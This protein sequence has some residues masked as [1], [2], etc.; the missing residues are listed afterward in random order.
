MHLVSF[1]D[2]GCCGAAARTSQLN[3]LTE[4]HDP[5]LV[6]LD[7]SKYWRKTCRCLACTHEQCQ[8]SHLLGAQRQ[9]HGATIAAS[10]WEHKSE[11]LSSGLQTEPASN[12]LTVANRKEIAD[13]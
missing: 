2:W 7:R 10:P 1:Q 5:M 11:L 8:R 3:R 9:H 6:R 4:S 13:E 12:S